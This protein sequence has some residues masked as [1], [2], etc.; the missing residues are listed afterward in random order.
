MHSLRLCGESRGGET[1]G[2]R[3]ACRCAC[4]CISVAVHACTC[5]LTYSPFDAIRVEEQ[6]YCIIDVS[7]GTYRS[8]CERMSAF[9]QS[10]RVHLLPHTCIELLL[11]E[12]DEIKALDATASD[13]EHRRGWSSRPTVTS[14]SARVFRDAFIQSN[15]QPFMHTFTH[16]R[17]SQ[18]R[19]QPGRREQSG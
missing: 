15:L 10:R 11:R 7:G 9:Y 14:A 4:R 1:R 5:G 13:P 3:C 19:Q 2:R 6:H 17:W 8:L 16:R 12:P 18:P